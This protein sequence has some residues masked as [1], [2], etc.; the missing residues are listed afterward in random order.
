MGDQDHPKIVF[1]GGWLDRADGRRA[2][3]AWVEAKANEPQARFL[4]LR[5]L[6]IGLRD[7]PELDLAWIERRALAEPLPHSHCILLGVDDGDV[8]HFAV[9]LEERECERLA[10]HVARFTDAR[11]AALQ[12]GDR[13]AAVVAHARSLLDWHARH[14]YC[15]VCGAPSRMLHGG[16][17]RLCTREACGAMHFPRTDPVVIMMVESPDGAECLLGR[18]PGY[19]GGLVSALA[20]FVEPAES[21]EE[22]VVRELKEEA[23]VEC[24][25]IRYFASQPWP[26]PSSLMIACFARAE[27]KQLEVDHNELEWARWF[28][29]REVEHMFNGEID[30]LSAPQ[31]IAIAYHM[32]RHWLNQPV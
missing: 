2:D 26:F 18:S 22:A 9:S 13:R 17:Q 4:P 24:G 27:S 23:G 28:S 8:G 6:D 19:P 25:D 20:G 30:G 12:L 31:P 29:R 16:G 1:T 10:A 21:I 11:S 14:G 5:G 7:D 15:A 3:A 32:L